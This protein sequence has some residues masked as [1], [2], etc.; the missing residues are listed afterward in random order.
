V[1]CTETYKNSK[2]KCKKTGQF[3]TLCKG[4]DRSRYIRTTKTAD[5]TKYDITSQHSDLVGDVLHK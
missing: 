2:Y 3:T 4:D 5:I 1:N